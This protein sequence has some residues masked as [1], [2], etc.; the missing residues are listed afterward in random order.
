MRTQIGCMSNEFIAILISLYHPFFI[1]S[2][3]N[4]LY[5]N[6]LRR[7]SKLDIPLSTPENDAHN[8]VQPS[9]KRSHVEIN[10]ADLHSIC[11]LHTRVSNYHPNDH[12]SIRRA[13]LQKGSLST[14]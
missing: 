2:L 6:L 12:D 11:R 5:I 8:Q 13:Y 3:L 14:M 10:L 1:G 4:Q 9:L 7:K